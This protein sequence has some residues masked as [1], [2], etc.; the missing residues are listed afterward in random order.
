MYNACRYPFCDVFVMRQMEFAQVEDNG[1]QHQK[2]KKT[3]FNVF[4]LV[5][6]YTKKMFAAVYL[7]EYEHTLTYDRVI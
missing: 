7:R 6:G 1:K 5:H 2:G 4:M 3:E